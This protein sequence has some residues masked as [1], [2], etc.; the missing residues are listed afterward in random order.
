M[1]NEG[2]RNLR[3][4]PYFMQRGKDFNVFWQQRLTSK[5]RNIL[6]ILG[7]G[8]DPRMCIGLD[9]LLKMRG[10]GRR[11]CLLIHFDEG[12]D[13]P[14]VELMERVKHNRFI[15]EDVLNNRGTILEKKVQMWSSNG[16]DRRRTS[17]YNSSKIFDDMSVITDYTDIII[18]ISALP[19]AIYFSLTA[20]LLFLTDKTTPKKDVHIV[21]CEDA[22]LDEDI[23][24]VGIDET[25]SFI[26]GFAG[27]SMVSEGS[28]KIP[29]IWIPIL[30]ENQRIQLSKIFSF[31]NPDEICPVLPHPSNNP[32]RSD[33]LLISYRD[34]IFD[35]WLVE[36]RNIIY[37][38][39]QN[40]FDVYR[41]IINVVLRYNK[42]LRSLGGCKVAISAQS[43][44]LISIG[45]LLAA[46][47]L[48]T[49]ENSK[50][51]GIVHI[52]SLGY[53]MDMMKVTKASGELFNLWIQGECYDP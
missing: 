9:T 37:A 13:S 16:L 27:S 4:D 47:D 3:W 31:V 15:L 45:A 35:Q 19:S 53:D 44:K 17:S 50:Q 12:P 51:V 42:A 32:R 21:V 25:A 1:P 6:F 28:S 34:L 43:N 10:E 52:E 11:D 49:N 14:S 22:L 23:Q 30:G 20:K 41:Q 8:F 46:Y 24:E 39:E 18:D 38:S 29:K 48:K 40:P 26:H 33:N 5:A 7:Q 36:P 2:V